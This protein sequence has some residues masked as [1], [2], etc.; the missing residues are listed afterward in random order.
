MSAISNPIRPRCQ[1]A[2][3]CGLCLITL[4]LTVAISAV[5][6]SEN[7]VE[8]KKMESRDDISVD[9][10]SSLTEEDKVLRFSEKLEDLE[11]SESLR[12]EK[13]YRKIQRQVHCGSL[14]TETGV[15]KNLDKNVRNGL[16]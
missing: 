9:Y 5:Q 13:L 1:K 16:D 12:L 6:Q 10:S 8:E 2:A 11:L 14:V 3:L 15:R 4:L 7:S